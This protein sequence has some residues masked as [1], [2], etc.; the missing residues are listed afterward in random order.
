M[1]HAKGKDYGVYKFTSGELALHMMFGCVFFWA[2]GMIFFQNI[3]LAIASC[4]LTFF[5]IKERRAAEVN[6]VRARLLEQFREA[7]YVLVSALSAGRS[8]EQ[9]FI[10]SYK[11]LLLV[12]N[13]SDDIALEWALIGQKLGMNIP[14]ETAL[15]DFAKRSGLEDIENFSSIFLLAK[16]SGG[17]LVEI[18]K[19]TSRVINEKIEIKREIE[20]LIVQKK[21][22]Q[23]ILS[24]IIPGMICFFSIA[25]PEFLE[26][27]YTTLA[28]RGIMVLALVMY[29]LSG[30]IGRRIVDIEV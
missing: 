2:M 29:L 20:V 28:G 10:Q 14:V 26:P 15:S 5:Y 6:R 21:F 18:V 23:K 19:E 3:Y 30:V 13:P 7:M 17:N 11:D 4:G 22:E 12:C 1:A 16:R 8:V 9:A 27:L 24:Y 25:S